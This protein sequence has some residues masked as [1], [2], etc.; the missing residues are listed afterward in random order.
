VDDLIIATNTID[1]MDK[2]KGSLTDCFQ[3]KNLGKLHHCLGITIQRDMEN[4]HLWMHQ[5]QYICSML[6]KYGLQQAKT[7]STPADMSVK[8]KKDDGISNRVDPIHYQSMVGS[9]LYAAIATRPDI[10]YAVGAVSKFNSNPSQAHLT[11]VKRIMQYLKGTI[12]VAIEYR[13]SDTERLIGYAD[14]DWAGDTD[15]RHSTTGNLFLL[16]E[17]PISWLSKKQPIV[18][19]STPEAQ[20]VSL[21]SA[22]Q[23]AVWLR[24]LLA[25]FKEVLKEPTE[26]MEDNQGTIAIA[27]NPI[28]HARVKHIDIKYHY[29]CEAIQDGSISLSYCP[30]E[31]MLADILTKPVTR[32]RLETIREAMGLKSLT[33]LANSSGSVGGGVKGELPC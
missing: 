9:L 22:T 31:E 4:S 2:L 33:Q 13:K 26:L 14:A 24:K 12:D 21:C 6:K 27:R 15:D 20:Y 1:Q 16:A 17:G 10:A 30:T 18:T 29:T 5:K 11:A 32:K 23:E 28:S 25:D 3:M 7:V 19:L 8:L